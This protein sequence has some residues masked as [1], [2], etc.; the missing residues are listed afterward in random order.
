MTTI[1]NKLRK[2][3]YFKLSFFIILTS[4]LLY[5]GYIFGDMTLAYTDYGYDTFNTYVPMM[6]FFAESIK[7][8]SLSQY[9]FQY[10]Y[11]SSIFSLIQWVTDPFNMLSILWGII[12]GSG[13]IAGFI[14]Y[15]QILKHLC[16]G[17]LAFFFLKQLGYSSASAQMASYIYAFSGY[18]IAAGQHFSFGVLP[19]YSILILISIELLLKKVTFKS[20][21]LLSAVTALICIQDVY[22]AY[23]V[24]LG[25]A[26]YTLFRLIYCNGRRIKKVFSSGM[27]VFSGVISGIFLSSFLFLPRAEYIMSSSRLNNVSVLDKLKA[28]F[29]PAA[30][31]IILSCFARLFS[32]NMEGS[33]NDW[34]GGEFHWQ[35]FSCFFSVMLIPQLFQFI[36]GTFRVKRS[37]KERIARI[38]PII[39]FVFSILCNFVPQM[40]NGMEYP[41][42]RYAFIWQVPFAIMVADTLD[43]I[44]RRQFNRVINYISLL[45]SVIFMIFVAFR[46][47]G[48]SDRVT[49]FFTSA[50]AMCCITFGCLLLDLKYL[51]GNID[52][53]TTS[54]NKIK[55]VLSVMFCGV[56]VFNLYGENFT[57]LYAGRN[58]V[59][60]ETEEGTMVADAMS[61]YINSIEQ[62]N[63][64]RTETMVFE[65]RMPF[66]N[67]H[68]IFPLRGASYYNS[69]IGPELIE[70][71]DKL[72]YRNAPFYHNYKEVFS[73]YTNPVDE[74][75]FGVKYLISN[76]LCLD[77]SWEQIMGVDST[78]LYKNK[79]INSAGLLYDSYI[80]Q[81]NANKLSKDERMYKMGEYVI[82]DIFDSSKTEYLNEFNAE[83]EM[84]DFIGDVFDLNNI[85]L[86]KADN[87]STVIEQDNS[88]TVTVDTTP[89]SSVIIPLNKK[90]DI[91]SDSSSLFKVTISKSSPVGYFCWSNPETDWTMVDSHISDENDTTIEYTFYLPEAANNIGISL[92]YEGKTI[93]NISR[94]NSYE[95]RYTSEGVEL[96]NPDRGSLIYGNIKSQNNSILFL[97]VPFDKYWTAELDGNEA[98]IIKANY[99]FMA[100]IIPDGEH[101]IKLVYNN[102]AFKIGCIISICT[103]SILLAAVI[104][105]FIR[106]RSKKI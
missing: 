27:T 11:G 91:H 74:D 80:T 46:T 56:I 62:D 55:K 87:V 105:Y 21:L 82:L 25:A 40:F 41:S 3:D 54:A 10:G 73:P 57:V 35:M 52:S 23:Q 17:I 106:K 102:K 26:F 49:T 19:V 59:S 7:S 61:E 37:L 104:G 90:D 8:G 58:S 99:G 67:Y 60:K 85:G 51:A 15:M 64:F 89:E 2:S 95:Y 63:F 66:Y 93:F 12:F 79:N 84:N 50:F 65:G 101:M 78:Y 18:I 28:A 98:D 39:V 53:E 20:F 34:Y 32:L 22:W 97:P 47:Y 75:V 43:M 45:C 38:L 48:A 33:V 86:Y 16:S 36:W 68:L 4:V 42:G 71:E 96:F 31:Q 70:M 9:T 94:Q 44:S 6:E 76:D 72:L 5:F 14:V 30:P 83:N 24:L 77:D 100:I 1:L 29:S 13:K 69:V 88:V 103:A 81:E 92:G